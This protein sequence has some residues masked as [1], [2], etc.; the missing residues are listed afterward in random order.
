LSEG[1]PAA[2]ICSA[3][4]GGAGGMPLGSTSGISAANPT[5]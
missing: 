5:G 4:G 1:R 2:G 3:A